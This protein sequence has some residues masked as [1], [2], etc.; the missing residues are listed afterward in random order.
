MYK[1]L[2]LIMTKHFSFTIPKG[3]TVK[4]NGV[5]ATAESP[6]IPS[7][8]Y[9]ARKYL[10][11]LARKKIKAH[12]KEPKKDFNDYT[13]T[14]ETIKQERRMSIAANGEFFPFFN[15]KW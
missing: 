4:T 6:E 3:A 2:D 9:P 10:I 8:T 12:V 11:E 13:V 1:V 5:P 14:T 7:K 15:K